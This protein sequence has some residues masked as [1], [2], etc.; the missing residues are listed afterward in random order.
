M[1]KYIYCNGKIYNNE[2]SNLCVKSY[3][4]ISDFDND[5]KY[6]LV[7]YHYHNPCCKS[8]LE[9]MNSYI[10]FDNFEDLIEVGDIIEFAVDFDYYVKSEVLDFQIIGE[11]DRKVINVFLDKVNYQSVKSIWK[12]VNNTFIRVCYKENGSWV[13]D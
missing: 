13:I 1:S 11:D 10:E 7:E 3:E 5:N 9:H 12:P 4:L 8:I 6:R 2:N